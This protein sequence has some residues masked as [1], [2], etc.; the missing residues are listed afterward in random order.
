MR[1]PCLRTTSESMLMLCHEG[2]V[3]VAMKR[4]VIPSSVTDRMKK[5]RNRTLLFTLVALSGPSFAGDGI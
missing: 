2:G 3:G 5:K 1:S 4:A